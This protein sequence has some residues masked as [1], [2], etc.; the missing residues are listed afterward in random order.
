ME[1]EF[2]FFFRIVV[3]DKMGGNWE[4]SAHAERAQ[5]RISLVEKWRIR[6]LALA[7]W[8]TKKLWNKMKDEG[9]IANEMQK[10]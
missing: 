9:S 5:R 3:R 6:Q 8:E 7:N 10:L 4:Q 2:V 1:E